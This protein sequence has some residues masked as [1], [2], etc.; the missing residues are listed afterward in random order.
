VAGSRRSY[1]FAYDVKPNLFY[2]HW[3]VAHKSLPLCSFTRLPQRPGT[4]GMEMV[5]AGEGVA[6]AGM[7]SSRPHIAYVGR[8]V[9]LSNRVH[10]LTYRD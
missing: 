1:L 2:L 6:V 8:T 4:E 7:L 3:S 9:S 10:V 5:E